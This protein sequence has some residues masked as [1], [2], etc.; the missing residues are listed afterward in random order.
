MVTY[1]LTRTRPKRDGR[2]S[3]EDVISRL[4]QDCIKLLVE[5]CLK[6]LK[7]MCALTETSSSGEHEKRRNTTRAGKTHIHFLPRFVSRTKHR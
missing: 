1:L 7:V 3:N 5:L 2:Q 4:S 6:F